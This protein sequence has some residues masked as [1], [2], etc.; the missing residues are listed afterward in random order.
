MKKS[1][2]QTLRNIGRKSEREKERKGINK[3]IKGKMKKSKER[4]K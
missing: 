2:L 1:E 3:E 4:K